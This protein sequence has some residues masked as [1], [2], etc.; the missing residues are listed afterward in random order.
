MSFTHDQGCEITHT[1]EISC[2]NAL[3][4]RDV[5]EN[6]VW[7]CRGETVSGYHSF[8]NE[9]PDGVCRNNG[10]DRIRHELSHEEA[11]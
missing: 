5:A 6:D 3:K 4:A 10:C 2:V 9:D 11:P 7:W 1:G 8:K